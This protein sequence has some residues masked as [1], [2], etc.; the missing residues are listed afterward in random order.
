MWGRRRRSTLRIPTTWPAPS[1][2]W[3]WPWGWGPPRAVP[4]Q[5]PGGGRGWGGAGGAQRGCVPFF[6][7]ALPLARPY[8]AAEPWTSISPPPAAPSGP[9]G[10]RGGGGAAP[11]QPEFL[12]KPGG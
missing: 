5:L 2:S 1:L 4:G 3:T 12:S 6:F 10:G 7:S 9:G 8:L 11:P